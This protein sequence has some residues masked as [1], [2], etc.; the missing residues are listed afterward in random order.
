MPAG[1]ERAELAMMEDDTEKTQMRYATA[2]SDWGRAR[3]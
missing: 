2:L 3:L 1:R